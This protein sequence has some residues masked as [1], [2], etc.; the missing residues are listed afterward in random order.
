MEKECV[1]FQLLQSSQQAIF[2]NPTMPKE[3]KV[4]PKQPK[5]IG[6]PNTPTQSAV[7]QESRSPYVTPISSSKK[8]RFETSLCRFLGPLVSAN[9]HKK[10]LSYEKYKAAY[11]R[12][13]S[14]LDDFMDKKAEMQTLA[15]KRNSDLKRS[16]E[17]FEIYFAS[18]NLREPTYE[19]Y[20]EDKKEMLTTKQNSDA[21]LKK[22]RIKF[23]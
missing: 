3:D 10:L 21:L 7:T 4:Q 8:F 13:R 5:S 11:K 19:D 1:D 17:D 14:Y 15:L 6:V 2:C 16:L 22:W 12:D 18:A 9:D 20:T 23:V